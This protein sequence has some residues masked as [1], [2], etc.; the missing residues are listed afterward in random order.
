M[1]SDGWFSGLSLTNQGIDTLKEGQM[2]GALSTRLA[3][4]I[5]LAQD[6]DS[7]GNAPVSVDPGDFIF[8]GGE[9]D[10]LSLTLPIAYDVWYLWFTENIILQDAF[11]AEQFT[12]LIL[13]PIFK[14]Y[15]TIYPLRTLLKNTAIGSGGIVPT[16]EFFR[17]NGIDCVKQMR[18][19]TFLH[20]KA[21]NFVSKGPDYAN[22][23]GIN[24]SGSGIADV[25][26]GFL[27]FP[28]GPLGVQQ[29]LSV[30]S[31]SLLKK[32]EYQVHDDSL[33]P[34]EGED[35]LS[36]VG[37]Q[38]NICMGRHLFV[39]AYI[40]SDRDVEYPA[41]VMSG[42]DG[43]LPHHWMRLW[44][45]KDGTW[46][47]PGEFIA[48]VAKPVGDPPHCWW[49]QRTSPFLY[50][51]NFF[52][53]EYYTS[54]VILAV[55][56]VVDYDDKTQKTTYEVKSVSSKNKQRVG[57]GETQMHVGMTYSDMEGCGNIYKI[58]IKN[59]DLYL[60]SS[61]FLIYT[62][63]QIVSVRKSPGPKDNF[64]W[65]DLT[66]GRIVCGSSVEDHISYYN[67]MSGE[68]FKINEDWVIVPVTFYGE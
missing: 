27:A 19:E 32:N 40:R 24:H 16:L 54:G 22:N 42:H 59:Q 55:I 11:E 35:L 68:D 4:L 57:D 33:K 20:D 56:E 13:D 15:G 36:P 28:C 1:A 64:I 34:I 29:V 44:L 31:M 8:V 67:Q 12:E 62:I 14:Q 38:T 39:D 52:E 37:A 3:Q 46:P 9:N 43:I 25:Y 5:T 63:D 50:S 61:D 26:G 41:S 2:S 7:Q 21:P 65:T 47:V 6:K 51:G 23:P 30:V 58:R 49:Y 66:D 17:K 18:F 60:K 48:M 10:G 53:T 45:T